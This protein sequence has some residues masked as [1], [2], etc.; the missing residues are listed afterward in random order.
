MIFVDLFQ[1][2][3][4]FSVCS[5]DFSVFCEN[6]PLIYDGIFLKFIERNFH[7]EKSFGVS[8]YAQHFT[9]NAVDLYVM[10]NFIL[11]HSTTR[12]HISRFPF[13]TDIQLCFYHRKK[14]HAITFVRNILSWIPK[15]QD[16][17]SKNK[18]STAK[19]K[20]PRKKT[21]TYLFNKRHVA[22]HTKSIHSEICSLH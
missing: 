14:T 3:V 2:S 20:W 10:S 9:S 11:G 15:R 5:W 12:R 18:V 1:F 19:K 13:H 4:F 6:N 8:S 21:H 17:S 7:F 16:H 22:P